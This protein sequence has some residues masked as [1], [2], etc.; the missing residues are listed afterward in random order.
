MGMVVDV[1]SEGLMTAG[2][3]AV[4]NAAANLA[5]QPVGERDHWRQ[6]DHHVHWRNDEVKIG[7]FG[8]DGEGDVNQATSS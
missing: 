6:I 2:V 7:Q 3:R 4:N 5:I 8:N 1:F